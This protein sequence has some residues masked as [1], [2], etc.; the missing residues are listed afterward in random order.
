VSGGSVRSG[1]SIAVSFA[2]IA[3]AI[4]VA[5]G[6]LVFGHTAHHYLASGI[7]N[8]LL[9][10]A[11]AVA[12][13][14]IVTQLRGQFGGIQD[15]SAALGAAIAISIAAS[16]E[17][18]GESVVFA[19]ILVALIGATLLTGLFFLV[20]GR[21]RLGNLVRFVPFPVVAGFLAAT[22]WLILK[23]GLEVSGDSHLQVVE[24]GYWLDHA[25][26][27]QAVLALAFGAIAYLLVSRF[28]RALWVLPAIIVIGIVGFFAVTA[29]LGTSI[30]YLEEHY[31]LIGPLPDAPFWEAVTLPDPGLVEWDVIL[32]QGG[33]LT[34]IM[35]SAIALMVTQSG[36]EL[37][38]ERD[39]DVNDELER[40][41]AVNVAISLL[42]TPASWVHIPSTATA[43]ERRAM[44]WG[45]GVLAA[46]LMLL[47][48]LAGP[49][50]VSYFPRIIAG[51][52]LVFLGI[53][54][55]KEWLW[56]SRR[57]MPRVDYIIVIAIVV[58]VEVFGFIV[59]FA[60]GVVASILI[61]VVRYSSQQP[62]RERLDGGTVHSGRDRPIPDERLLHYH[63]EK[64]VILQL[65]GFIFFGTAYTLYRQVK[66]LM[67]DP[68][69]RP[70]FLVLDMRLVQGMDSSAA[71][72]FVKTAK[73]FN[74]GA[75]GLVIVPGSVDVARS[76]EQAELTA[77]H[78]EHLR[79]F[80]HFDAAIEWC[81]EQV[82]ADARKQLQARGK[83]GDDEEFL[84]A[85]FGD[86]MAALDVQE[87]FEEVVGLLRERLE[88]FGIEEGA[89]LFEQQDE[90]TQL[91]FIV[92]GRVVLEKLGF[93]GESVRLGTLGSWNIV[94]ELGALL[95]YR[96][97]FT[98]RVD[99]SGEILALA[100]EDLEALA[101]DDPELSR[102]LQALT[103]QLMGSKLAKT[104]QAAAQ[105]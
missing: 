53:E 101:T 42:A 81:E 88:P 61:F 58:V 26:L 17:E 89:V 90:N 75:A 14:G 22:G 94:G 86:M 21:F 54:L 92:N 36:L 74:D 60:V 45:F 77:D 57:E 15:V 65:Q 62:I 40:S 78:F 103:I 85:V 76:L 66:E 34:V 98:A 5:F 20:V 7:A 27:E 12:L 84:D 43:Y 56:G 11:V 30:E 41:G 104:T 9:G 68:E 48:F 10:G 91:F 83:G 31:W 18:L 63:D 33:I 47:A 8:F 28:E 46:G 35:V 50:L 100:A 96:E 64:T 80:S 29:M 1:I 79:L 3:I 71:S 32:V 105:P 37:A 67:E 69:R 13:L 24:L 55:L 102:R 87:E 6:T 82:L 25:H 16:L 19:N 97:P 73:L 2:I 70:S 72:T 93:Q 4:A 23:G 38:L 49:A 51:G 95:G 39:M 44:H 59:G 99:R 52:I